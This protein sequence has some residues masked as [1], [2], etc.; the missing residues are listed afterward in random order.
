MYAYFNTYFTDV[1]LELRESQ[2]TTQVGGFQGHN[3]EQQESTRE[4]L[5]NLATNTFDQ[6]QEMA[7][8]ISTN[9]V[10]TDKLVEALYYI[11]ELTK[12]LADS[13]G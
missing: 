9:K 3:I 10:L 6:R 7:T 11:T 8:L 2:T 12:L 13:K 1:H 4:S 5:A